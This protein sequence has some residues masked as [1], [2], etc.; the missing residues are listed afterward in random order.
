MFFIYIVLLSGIDY[1]D[2]GFG[3]SRYEGFM[4]CVVRFIM[5]W[6]FFGF[7][8]NLELFKYNKIGLVFI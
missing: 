1:F 8:D 3:L 4:M 5:E 6:F 2:K 7:W